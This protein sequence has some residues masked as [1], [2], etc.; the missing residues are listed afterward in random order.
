MEIVCNEN[1]TL[2]LGAA[3][4][5]LNRALETIRSAPLL[6][7]L[8]GG[9]A[10]ELL[11][12]VRR[13]LLGTHTT[14]SVLDER[15]STDP[16][17]SNFAQL[18]GLPFFQAAQAAGAVFINT[19]V[20]GRETQEALAKRLEEALRSWKSTHP[21]GQVVATQGIGADGHTAG[22][23][24]YMG[25]AGQFRQLFENEERW[26]VAYDATP[27]RN[28]HPLRVTVTMP[29]LRNV[30]DESIVYAVGEEKRAALERVYAETGTL[31][32]TPAR[33]VREMKSA[34]LFTAIKVTSRMQQTF[35]HS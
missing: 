13:E 33:I 7:L 23:F 5:A 20:E 11:A 12:G 34:L 6:L 4:N 19:R 22:I 25:V 3:T 24:P 29:F 17:I 27:A 28:A 15:Y 14:I 1:Q 32:E 31:F 18:V 30:I 35:S 16:K 8:S 9:S 26:V 10:L 2:L 21:D